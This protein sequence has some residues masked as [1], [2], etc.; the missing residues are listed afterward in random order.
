MLLRLLSVT[1]LAAVTASAAP[2]PKTIAPA[3]VP[4]PMAI[5]LSNLSKAGKQQV[6]FRAAAVS[7]HFFLEEPAGVT[8]YTYDETVGYRKEAFLKGSTLAKAMKKY[9]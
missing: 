4:H 3:T 1:L 5:Y 2:P 6:T 8:V 9:K 7:T